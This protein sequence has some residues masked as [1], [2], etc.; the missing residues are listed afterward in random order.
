MTGTFFHTLQQMTLSNCLE[1]ENE[2]LKKIEENFNY[3]NNQSFKID[4]FALFNEKNFNNLF[5]WIDP[6]TNEIVSHLGV[7]E[8]V[9]K[10]KLFF[11]L[12]GIFVDKKYRR[13]NILREMISFIEKKNSNLI[14]WSDQI[15]LYQKLGFTPYNSI[16]WNNPSSIYKGD[17]QSIDQISNDELQEVKNIYQQYK[18]PSF[19]RTNEH[20]SEIC[21]TTSIKYQIIRELNGSP[22]GYILFNKGADL[23]EIIHEFYPLDLFEVQYFSHLSTK[24]QSNDAIEIPGA[25]IK[26]NTHLED[27]LFFSGVDSI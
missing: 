1:R 5:L 27:N 9:I 22:K 11:C 10:D 23:T 19:S 25:L 7:K 2:L 12:G 17:L 15:E 6:K 16:Y 20:W 24:R 14:L 26:T 3:P 18:M 8:R 13:K 21:S 4:F